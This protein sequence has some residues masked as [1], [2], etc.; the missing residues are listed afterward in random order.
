MSERAAVYRLYD[1][2]D[3]LLYIGVSQQPHRRWQQHAQGK[4]WWPEVARSEIGTWFESRE[5][6]VLAEAA[7]IRSERPRYNI[8]RGANT[9]IRNIRVA[10]RLWN[11]ALAKARAEGRSVSEVLVAYLRRYV[12]APPRKPGDGS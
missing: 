8:R 3:V 6:A 4:R 9:P 12:A 5:L 1:A 7:A 11:A 2:Q 10:G